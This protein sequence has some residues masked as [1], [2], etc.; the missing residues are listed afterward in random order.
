[1]LT[2]S[3]R[4]F[5]S[6]AAQTS[7]VDPLPR[8]LFM[9]EPADFRLDP[10]CAQDNR[11]MQLDDRPDPALALVQFRRLARAIARLGVPVLCFPGRPDTPDAVFPNNVFATAPGR[12]I[13]GAMRHPT[14]RLEAERADVRRFLTDVLRY[15]LVDL[16]TEPVVAEL[17][18]ALVIDRRRRIGFCGRT[19]R[20]DEAGARAMDA[21]FDLTATL[22]F[23]LRPGEY[24]T[25]VLMSVLAGRALVLDPSCATDPA[26]VD[27][28]RASFEHVLELEA[29]ETEHFVANCLAVD[30][31]HVVMSERAADALRAT[32]RATLE[33]WG[34]RIC[35]V[36]VS[37]LEKAGGSVRCMLAEIF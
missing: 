24:H 3:I 10:Y 26:V 9:I 13:V 37:E 17:T 35:A 1:M 18:G 33:R 19:E 14:R 36:D 20:V 2:Q 4:E 28:L 31:E 12:A 21:A 32:S 25:N 6:L 34:F 16:S 11:Y 8:G 15:P 23:E 29:E 27:V 22:W 7:A 5:R 30:G